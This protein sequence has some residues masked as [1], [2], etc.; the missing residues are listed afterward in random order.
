MKKGRTAAGSRVRRSPAAVAMTLGAFLLGCGPAPPAA[1][2]TASAGTDRIRRV[3]TGLSTRIP[4]EGEPRETFTIEERLWHHHVP[5]VSIAV[6]DDGRIAWAKG[7]GEADAG[8]GVPVTA[9]TLFQ[10]A[11]ISKPVTAV[12]PAPTGR[13][14]RHRAV[15]RREPA[16]R[17]VASP[18]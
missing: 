3:E 9:R 12:G 13:A 16:A 5:G 14:R 18:R 15:R 6:I 4:I 8:T 2:A 17:P 7:Y 1:D 11:S 10:A